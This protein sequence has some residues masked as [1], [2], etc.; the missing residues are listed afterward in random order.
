M[1]IKSRVRACAVV[2]HEGKLLVYR[3]RDQVSGQEYDFIPGGEV[4]PEET[5]PEA[6]ERECLEET[7]FEVEVFPET[8]VEAEYF[9]TF[10]GQ[11]YDCLTLFYRARLKSPFASSPLEKH[12][13]VRWMES[14][15]VPEAF[16]YHPRIL[17]ALQECLAQDPK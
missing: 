14:A 15:A 6:A 8:C 4:E 12:L 17:A 2:V 5:A 13:G 10:N 7:G 11:E 16:E 9:F 3:D 1:Q